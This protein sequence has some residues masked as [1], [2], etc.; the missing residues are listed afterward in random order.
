M[1]KRILFSLIIVFIPAAVSAWWLSSGLIH[2]AGFYSTQPRVPSTET[3]TPTPTFAPTET[4]VPTVQPSP[5]ETPVP[6]PTEFRL[7]IPPT[8]VPPVGVTAVP[9]DENGLPTAHYI[10]GMN[11]HKQYFKLG[12][13][14]ASTHDWALYFGV[15]INEFDFQYKLPVSDNPEVGFVGSVDSK[16]GQTPPFAYGVHAAPVA[17]LLQD[18][19]VPATAVKNFNVLS[20][21]Q[22]I[23]ADKP[24]IVWV[25][26]NMVGGI[27][28]EYTAAD[29]QKVIVAAY[30]HVVIVTG[31]DQDHI[32][33]L[34]NNKYFE[35][36]TD[37]FINSW[38][39]LG[40]MALIAGK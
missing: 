40:N 34:N 33:Y 23:A 25:I 9:V 22:Q 8:P 24:V 6:E 4:Q 19:G 18:Y 28:A 15:D 39:V 20:L 13:E 1:R 7:V 21:K 31:Y 29:G 14:A 35:V 11:G 27:P 5:T 3:L 12:C 10:Y 2:A 16:W 36:P 32:R 26:G 37:V 38:K 17:R 30:E